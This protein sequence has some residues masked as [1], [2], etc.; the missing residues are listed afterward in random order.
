[1]VKTTGLRRR[2]TTQDILCLVALPT[3]PQTLLKQSHHLQSLLVSVYSVPGGAPLLS[4]KFPASRSETTAH[5]RHHFSEALWLV[6]GAYHT[7]QPQTPGNGLKTWLTPRQPGVLFP[8]SPPPDLGVL[9]L[10]LCFTSSLTG[11]VGTRKVPISTL[12]QSRWVRWGQASSRADPP[13]PHTSCLLSNTGL[14]LFSLVTWICQEMTHAGKGAPRTTQPRGGA[15][16][17]QG[18]AL[19]I[20]SAHLHSPG[21]WKHHLQ[22]RLSFHLEKVH[23]G[24]FC[25]LGAQISVF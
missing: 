14:L 25:W 7:L 17:G 4:R 8:T 9:S 19:H 18:T 1:M 11:F 6:W 15:A 2:G 24:G 13:S 3:A 23:L 12:T 10:T 21:P 16:W 22:L 5:P 20:P